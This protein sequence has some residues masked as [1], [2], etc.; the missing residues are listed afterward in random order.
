MNSNAKNRREKVLRIRRDRFLTLLGSLIIFA[1]F[2]VKEGISENLKDLV[3]SIETAENTFTLRQETAYR[4][5]NGKYLPPP[6]SQI[7]PT[8]DEKQGYIDLW[9]RQSDAIVR[10]S[11]DLAAVL[12]DAKQFQTRANQIQGVIAQ[13]DSEV[14]QVKLSPLTPGMKPQN[15]GAINGLFKRSKEAF[16]DANLFGQDVLD[17][18]NKLK[19]KRESFYNIAKW[20]SYALF[21]FGW[22]LTFYGQ[23]SRVGTATPKGSNPD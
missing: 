6:W 14:D 22:I 19:R 2:I 7:E 1:T 3:S 12:P 5:S 23:L 9:N 18:A 15:D 8:Q 11:L 16:S 20:V 21:T 17:E 4:L 10:I 13:I